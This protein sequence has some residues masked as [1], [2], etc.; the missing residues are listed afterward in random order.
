MY[1]RNFNDGFSPVIIVTCTGVDVICSV[2]CKLPILG[3]WV[4]VNIFHFLPE[5][6]HRVDVFGLNILPDAVFVSWVAFVL[7]ENFKPVF[8]VFRA[9]SF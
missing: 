4:L 2:R 7:I 5:E 9:Q 3:Y 6:I 8:P 1:I